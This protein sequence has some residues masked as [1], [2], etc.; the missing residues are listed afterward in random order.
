MHCYKQTQQT[1]KGTQ[2]DKIEGFNDELAN[3]I[4]QYVL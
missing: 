1:C 4:S 3:I 2:N